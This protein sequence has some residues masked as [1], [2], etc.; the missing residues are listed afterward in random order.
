M[1]EP[2]RNRKH[3]AR[4]ERERRLRNFLLMGIGAIVVLILG[5]L[6]YGWYDVNVRQPAQPVIVVEGQEIK[7][8][9]FAARVTLAQ[10]EL[11]N[12][13]QNT[14]SLLTFF[15]GDQEVRQSLEQELARIDGQ[16]KNP[17]VTGQQIVEQLIREVLI[18]NE[19]DSR[20]ITVTEEEVSRALEEDFGFYLEGTPTPGP[21]RTPVPT[22]TLDPTLQS[23]ITPSETPTQGPTPTPSYTPTPSATPTSYTLE[24]FEGNYTTYLEGLAEQGVRESDLRDLIRGELYREK[25]IEDFRQSLPHT[26]EQVNARHILVADEATAQE[27][28]GLLEAGDDFADLAAEYSTDSSNADQGGDLGWFGRG[29]M[30]EAFETAAFEAEVGEIVGPIETSFGFHIIEVMGHEERQ[31]DDEAFEGALQDAF[32]EWLLDA[33][34]NAD[35]EV[36]DSW[37]Q[38]IPTVPGQT[39]P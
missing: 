1:M 38:A 3:M 26:Q 7:R 14:Q 2:R 24:L 22:N 11:V 29:R 18:R 4:A 17:L 28:L 34:R 13:F 21:T 25:L 36:A 6:G 27:V 35:V 30:V 32:N 20:G 19:A 31:L 39:G 8:Q 37:I 15:G 16:L 9:A 33:R 12:Q 10:F 23:Q 5:V